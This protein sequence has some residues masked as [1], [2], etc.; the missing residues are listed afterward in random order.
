MLRIR[1]GA[2]VRSVNMRFVAHRQVLG[3][4]RSNRVYDRDIRGIVIM[5]QGIYVDRIVRNQANTHGKQFLR[6]CRLNQFKG[7]LSCSE[8]FAGTKNDRS[9]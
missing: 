7:I 5:V 6:T 4:Q 2:P 8:P 9:S 3:P 1:N